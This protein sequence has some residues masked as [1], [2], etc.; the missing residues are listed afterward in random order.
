MLMRDAIHSFLKMFFIFPFSFLI[1]FFSFL[2][3]SLFFFSFLFSTSFY[4]SFLYFFFHISF[5]ILKSFSSQSFLFSIPPCDN[6][7]N[8]IRTA[9]IPFPS[10]MSLKTP[11][12]HPQ[13]TMLTS[14]ANYRTCVITT[15]LRS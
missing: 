13:N 9:Y 1:S 14:S 15:T 7:L 6:L 8:F 3:F 2:F 11:T 10:T 5:H 4:F 12:A